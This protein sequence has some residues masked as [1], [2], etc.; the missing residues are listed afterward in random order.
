[1]AL[2]PVE[3]MFWGRGDEPGVVWMELSLVCVQICTNYIERLYVRIENGQ[4]GQRMG[5]RQVISLLQPFTSRHLGDA[6][7]THKLKP[8]RPDGIHSIRMYASRR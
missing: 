4:G 8:R 2:R 7:A 5:E 6:G 3:G 1:M